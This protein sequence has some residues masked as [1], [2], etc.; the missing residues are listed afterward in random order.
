MFGALGSPP[1]YTALGWQDQK[2][3]NYIGFF[4]WGNYKT[5]RRTKSKARPER[6]EV[7]E[8]TERSAGAMGALAQESEGAPIDNQPV[9]T[10]Y[11]CGFGC[12]PKKEP[13]FFCKFLRT[14]FT[15]A[16]G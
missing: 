13:C 11:S 2:T 5:P 8:A 7:A 10:L 3:K 9:Q 14:C 12:A 1:S 6:T 15:D 4:L 16:H